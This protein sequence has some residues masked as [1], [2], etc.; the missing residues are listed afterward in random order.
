MC[1]IKLKKKN[2]K[3]DPVLFSSGS[4]FSHLKRFIRA[5]VLTLRINYRSGL[6][7]LVFSAL[8][9]TEAYIHRHSVCRIIS[10][11]YRASVSVRAFTLKRAKGEAP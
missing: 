11:Y 6:S 5:I 9:S 7:K 8:F 4:D 3:S 1:I 2:L 10:I